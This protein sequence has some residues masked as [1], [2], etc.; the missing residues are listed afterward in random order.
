MSVR[1]DGFSCEY[2]YY[3]FPCNHNLITKMFRPREKI[4]DVLLG[5][6]YELSHNHTPD[7]LTF[8]PSAHN[9][10][11][12]P[13]D[14]F[15]CRII[16]LWAIEL[17]TNMNIFQMSNFFKFTYNHNLNTKAFTHMNIFIVITILTLKHLINVKTIMMFCSVSFMSYL[18]ITLRTRKL[19]SKWTDNIWKTN[20]TIFWGNYEII[21]KIMK[22]G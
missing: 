21:G 13:G 22:F 5:Y 8:G 7:T 1:S 10:N 4:Y 18:I 14:L 3:E 2:Y 9:S 20:G 17:F 12:L 16:T 19:L 6:F 15:C 11:G